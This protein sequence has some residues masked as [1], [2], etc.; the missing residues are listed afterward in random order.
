LK[1]LV[2]KNKELVYRGE[3]EKTEL[4]RQI[5]TQAII[6][7]MLQMQKELDGPSDTAKHSSNSIDGLIAGARSR[8]IYVSV[9]RI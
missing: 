2:V 9:K 7:E 3:K 8:P 4:Q 6:D 5:E 1:E